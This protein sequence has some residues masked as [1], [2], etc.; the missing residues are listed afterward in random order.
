MAPCPFYVLCLGFFIINSYF[1]WY[2]VY[3]ILFMLF[4]S[5]FSLFCFRKSLQV[6]S[7]FN[8]FI[9]CCHKWHNRTYFCNL[10]FYASLIFCLILCLIWLD[11]N[12]FLNTLLLILLVIFFNLKTSNINVSVPTF[13]VSPEYHLKSM[14]I[15]PE[16]FW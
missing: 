4:L 12:F 7:Y 13:V 14:A 8:L 11:I 9:S 6:S 3:T 5:L 10:I 16:V 2:F 15:A 1:V